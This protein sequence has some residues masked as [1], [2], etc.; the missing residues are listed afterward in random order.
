MAESIAGAERKTTPA[1]AL[2]KAETWTT[3]RTDASE[4]CRNAG[5][6]LRGQ[7]G[8]AVLVIAWADFAEKRVDKRLSTRCSVPL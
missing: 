3:A 5:T 7:V 6:H 2:I 8:R 1:R 4:D